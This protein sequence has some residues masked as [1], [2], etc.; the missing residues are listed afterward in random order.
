MGNQT[1]LSFM[2]R[3]LNGRALKQHLDIAIA[4]LGNRYEGI[5]LLK[6]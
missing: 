1:D 4:L 5:G 2:P 3:L 6:G